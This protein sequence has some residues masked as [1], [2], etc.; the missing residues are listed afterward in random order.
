VSPDLKAALLS[1]LAELDLDR[2]AADAAAR[3]AAKS[4]SPWTRARAPAAQARVAAAAGD[5]EQAVAL[6]RRAAGA[7]INSDTRDVLLLTVLRDQARL[8]A[9]RDPAAAAAARERAAELS[10]ELKARGHADVPGT[11]FPLEAQ[12]LDA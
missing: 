5:E 11:G 9:A 1:L 8:L 7:L 10:A 4:A 2:E 6:L 3:L 12:K